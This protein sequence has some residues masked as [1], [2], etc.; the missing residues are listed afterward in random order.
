MLKFPDHIPGNFLFKPEEIAELLEVSPG[1]VYA[2]IKTGELNCIKTVLSEI[3]I[4]RRDL[5]LFLVA[6]KTGQKT[7]RIALEPM[8]DTYLY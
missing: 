5:L 1:S 8:V 4:R 3:R 2:W 7:H 6:R